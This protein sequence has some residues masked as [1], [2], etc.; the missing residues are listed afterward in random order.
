MKA[1]RSSVCA[2]Q[3]EE[4]SCSNTQYCGFSLHSL[5]LSLLWEDLLKEL[6]AFFIADFKAAEKNDE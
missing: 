3:G 6:N 1:L 2:P 5:L 4:L